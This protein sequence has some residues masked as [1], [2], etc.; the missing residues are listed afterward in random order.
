MTEEANG[1]WEFAT[2][3]LDRD[4]PG[5]RRH[6]RSARGVHT[7]ALSTLELVVQYHLGGAVQCVV[8][9]AGQGAEEGLPGGG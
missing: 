6:S 3:S 8:Q 1:Q 2:R 7:A 9:L 4:G 5:D